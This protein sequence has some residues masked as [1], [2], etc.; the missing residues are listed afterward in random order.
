MLPI[1][2]ITHSPEETEQLAAELG[3]Y[4]LTLG[5]I[6]AFLALYG[7]LGAG[8]TAFVRGLASVIAPGAAVSSPTFAIVNEYSGENN[9]KL[10]H[11]DMYRITSEDDLYSIGFFDY[12]DC[13]MA[14]EWSE[15]IPFA[16]PDRYYR[17]EIRKATDGQA[18]DE[19]IITVEEVRA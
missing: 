1:S 10:C 5:K 7:D 18:V 12:E 19:R 15:N 3:A 16:L 14:V 9:I 6:D 2:K 4:L 17:V 13:V 11:F 8:K